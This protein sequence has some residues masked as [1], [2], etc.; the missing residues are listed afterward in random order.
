MILLEGW[1]YLPD[2]LDLERMFDEYF[3]F[4]LQGYKFTFMDRIYEKD[5]RYY[6]YNGKRTD[7]MK[8]N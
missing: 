8:Y 4:A 2:D 7:L 1:H 3:Q 5:K 6:K